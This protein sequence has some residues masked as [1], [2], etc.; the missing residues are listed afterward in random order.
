[1]ARKI[2]LTIPD[3]FV[4]KWLLFKLLAEGRGG[5][6]EALLEAIEL[7]LGFQGRIEHSRLQEIARQSRPKAPRP[8]ECD[9]PYCDY[10]SSL[11]FARHPKGCSC[12]KCSRLRSSR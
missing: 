6:E 11:G 3:Y 7:W 12:E 8:D 2:E 1:V 5:L 9:C 4:E 10:A